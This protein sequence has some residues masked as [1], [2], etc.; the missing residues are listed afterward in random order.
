MG[1]DKPGLPFGNETMLARVVRIVASV[2]PP[3]QVVVVTAPQQHVPRLP[4]GVTR[5]CDRV[6]GRGPLEGLATGMLAL[7]PEVEAVFVASC[8]QPLLR[9]ELIVHL[10]KLLGEHEAVVPRE[11]DRYHPLTAVY[12]RT[13]VSQVQRRIDAGRFKLQD[14]VE[15]LDAYKLAIDE[16]AAIDPNAESLSNVNSPEEYAAALRAAGLLP[17]P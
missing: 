17:H 1:R 13:V 16:L 9:S 3:S 6:T 11:G 5:V 7:P 4:F 15:N 2:V 8:D 10:F 14:L 12:R